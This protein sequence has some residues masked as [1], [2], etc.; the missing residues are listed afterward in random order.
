MRES[1][2]GRNGGHGW[3]ARLLLAGCLAVLLAPA[4]RG[5]PA[6]GG[7]LTVDQAV[8]EALR[9]NPGLAAAAYDLKAARGTRLSSYSAVLPSIS[10]Q[11]QYSQ[12][13]SR[14]GEPRVDPFT[15][16]IITSETDDSYSLSGSVSQP[17]ISP[18]DWYSVSAAGAS[19]AASRQTF[20]IA[21]QDVILTVR[22]QFFNLVGA[23]RLQQVAAEALSVAEEQ[24]RRSQALFD[25]GSVA[26]SD[27]LQAQVNRATAERDEIAAR[28]RVEQER[29]FLATLLGRPVTEEIDVTTDLPEPAIEET[30]E[31]GEPAWIQ[32]AMRSK[33]ELQRARESSRAAHLDYRSAFWSQFPSID[34]SL[35]YSKTA[36]SRADIWDLGHLKDDARWGFTLGLRWDI[37][38]GLSKIGAVQRTNAQAL[39]AREE[40]RRQEL[41]TE[42]DVREARIAIQNARESISAAEASVQLAEEN[43]KLQQA[44]YENGGG[45]ILELNN[46]QAELTR[47]RVSLVQ[48]QIDLHLAVAQLQR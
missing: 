48:A 41:Q 8:D 36:D 10:L 28:N 14:Y 3:N 11:T 18:S 45:T 29:A 1:R 21:R 23:I 32:E 20:R 17:I 6:P 7:P 38:P 24:L 43:L 31:A 33:P 39:A 35:F 25:L 22:Q 37:F 44:L 13:T 2:N 5:Q 30:G 27:V 42:L 34:G 40:V 47:A 15:N 19:L 16:R 4:V 12:T 26:R 46:A 9:N